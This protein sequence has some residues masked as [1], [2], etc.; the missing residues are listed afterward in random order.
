MLA[1]AEDLCDSKL[2]HRKVV[3]LPLMPRIP[4]PSDGQSTRFATYSAAV[5]I[6]V[7]SS[8]LVPY[9]A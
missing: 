5:A 6:G 1:S 4:M 3:G 7:V 2:E 8:C 9:V